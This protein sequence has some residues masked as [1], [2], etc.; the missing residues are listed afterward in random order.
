MRK[1]KNRNRLCVNISV[2]A[3]KR[4][5]FSYILVICNYM[6]ASET[7]GDSNCTPAEMF[8]ST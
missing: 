2:F 4:C 8:F 7:L 6:Y 1:E 5:K 3:I